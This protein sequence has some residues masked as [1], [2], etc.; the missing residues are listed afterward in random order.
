MQR[1]SGI[2]DMEAG[3]KKIL[4]F[5][6]A[7]IILLCSAVSANAAGYTCPTY[8]KYI[9]CSA[10][11]YLSNCG[12]ESNWTGQTIA[13]SALSVGNS[14]IK[15][16][17]AAYSYAGGRV[18]PKMDKV[19]CSAGQ[20]LPKNSSAC[21]T[22]K[23]GNYCEG[24]S[25][26]V[27]Y[28]SDQGLT[29][30][31]AGTANASTG[32][33]TVSACAACANG[34]Y[35]DATGQTSC[36]SCP[37]ADSTTQRTT[38]PDEYYPYVPGTSSYDKTTALSVL[39][40]ASQSWSNGG[41]SIAACK[42]IYGIE[43]A[44]G[45]FTVS[46][47]GYNATTKKYDVGGS[48]YYHYVKPGYYLDTKYLDTYC[49]TAT[50]YMFYRKAIAC[51][52]GAYC[53][54]GSTPQCNT[55]TYA[56]T[57]GKSTCPTN[58][59]SAA[60][61]TAQAECY[62]MITLDKNK[63]SG[64][65]LDTVSTTPASQKCFYGVA[66]EFPSSAVLSYTGDSMIP[67]K[68]AFNGW[69]TAN[70]CTS[71]T[72][73]FT[74]TSTAA[75]VTYYACR[76]Q[77]TDITFNLNGG[78]G[79]KP[80]D[81]VADKDKAMP[82]LG[83]SSNPTRTG[84]DFQGWYDNADYTKGT[85]YYTAV[86]AS[87][88]TWNKTAATATLYAGWKAQ[89]YTCAAGYYLNVTACA[90]CSAGY[91]CPAESQTYTYNG[92]IQ[93]RTACPTAAS[94]VGDIGT[95][96]VTAAHP[97][98]ASSGATSVAHCLALSVPYTNVSNGS[99]LRRCFYTSGAS[100]SAVYSTDCQ[101][102]RPTSCNAGAQPM[103]D[104]AYT[105]ASD[106][107]GVVCTLCPAGTYKSSAGMAAC[108]SCPTNW[109][110]A[111]GANA[112]GQCYRMITLDKNGG[113]G[114]IA[115]TTATGA[116]SNVTGT[117]S[118][119]HRCYYNTSCNLPSV[120]GLT[121]A[122]Y[123]YIGWGTSATCLDESTTARITSTAATVKYYACKD[124]N[125]YAITLDAN[126][127]SGGDG[128]VYQKYGHGWSL[129]NFGS[130]IP[131]L[132]SLPTKSNSL[133]NGYY[134]A[135]TNG[136]QR[137]PADGVLPAY[138]TFTA[139]TTIYAQYSACAACTKGT[140]VAS[141]G[142]SVKN[143]ACTY[144]ATCS[145]GYKTPTCTSAGACSCTPNTYNIAF[146]LNGAS[147][148]KPATITCTYGT[149][150]T[151]PM[152][153]GITSEDMV[154]DG[155]S[156]SDNSTQGTTYEAG[157]S[158]SDL[159]TTDNATVTLYARLLR[160]A[161]CDLFGGVG[162]KCSVSVINNQCVYATSCKVNYYNL[163]GG[164]THHPSCTKCPDNSTTPDGNS[165]TSCACNTGYSVDGTS[166]GSTSTTGNACTAITY[167]ISYTLNG[168]TQATSGV[169]TSYTYG[170]A[171]TINGI[172]TRSGYVFAGWCTN[173]GLTSCAMSQ[174]VA[175]D[176]TGD[177]TFYAKWTA[178]TCAATHGS[179][180][181][182][183]ITGNAPVCAITCATGYS[184]NGGADSTGTFNVTG[185]AGNASASGTCNAR[186]FTVTYACGTGTTGTAPSN[187]TA[188]YDANFTPAANSSCA[189]VG[190]TFAGW[191]DGTTDRAAGTAFKW[192]YSENKTF[193]AKWTPITF[194]VAYAAG[195]GSGSAPSAP[196]TC[197]YNGTCN[198]PANT[199]SRS[200]YTFK[201][202]KCTSSSGNC[203]AATYNAGAGISTATTV[204]GAT[205]TLTA[206]WNLVTYTITY[207]LN[208]GTN[209]A[210]NPANYNVTTNTITLQNPTREN[211]TFGGWFTSSALTGTAVTQIANGS[212][213]NKTF[214]AKWSCNTGYTASADGN[215][216]VAR[217]DL[218]CAAGQYLDG[219]T[220]R[221]CTSGYHC[222]ATKQTYTYNGGIQGRSGC[223]TA[224]SASDAKATSINSCYLTTTATKYVA[225]AGAGLVT[226]A[227]GG[228][229]AGGIK[230]YYNGTGGR[231]PCTS[232]NY[233]AAGASV[234]S[235]CSDL[236]GISISGTYTSVSPF[237]AKTTCR[238]TADSKTITGCSNVTSNTVA[239]AGT[240]W[241]TPTY[242]VTASGGYIIEN[243]DT[244]N[245]TCSACGDGTYST[246][247]SATSCS[248]C[249]AL[250]PAVA[251]T[252]GNYTSVSPRNANSTCRYKAPTP[253]KPEHCATMV[254]NTISYSGTAWGTNIYT[255]TANAGAIIS[256]NNSAAATC[257]QCAAGGYSAGGTATSCT[258][259]AAPYS[260]SAA[261]ST[262]RNDCYLTTD[263]GNYVKVA[264]GGQVTCEKGNYCTGGSVVYYGGTVA[265]RNTTGGMTAC[266]A[267]KYNA[268]T[269]SSAASA[270]V[271][272]AT[273]SYASGTGNTS[274]TACQSGKTT[275]G[276]GQTSCNANCGNAANVGA[277]KSA[278]WAANTV[279][280]LCAI[281]AAAANACAPAV[282][283]TGAASASYTVTG[284][285][286]VY[287]G[288]CQAKFYNPTASG[289]TVSCSGCPAAYPNS[290]AGN[291][292]DS[293]AYCYVTLKAG[294]QVASAGA[295]VTDCAKGHYCTSAGNIFKGTAG[296][297]AQYTGTACQN[298]S[299]QDETG[300]TV[301]KAC[302][303]GKTNSGT[304]NVA[305]CTT[306]CTAISGLSAWETTGWDAG[307]VS[308]L[309]TVKTCAAD[310][311]KNG[312]ACPTCS[313]G[314]GGK[315]PK[316]VAG[317][318]S[319]N[320]C[321]LITDAGKYVAT[322]KAGQ[323]ECLADNYCVGNM[324]VY[325]GTGTQTG[326]SATCG[327]G[328]NNK[329]TK[330][331]AG[332][333]DVAECYLTLTAGH[334]VASAGAGVTDCGAGKYCSSTANIYYSADGGTAT[335][336]G[337]NCPAGTY[338]T[339]G[340][341]NS[342]CTAALAGYTAAVCGDNKYSNAGA[343][344]CSNC[345]TD[346]KY[347][348]SG[349]TAAAH[350]GVASCKASC[351]GSEYVSAAGAGCV[352]VGDGY[353]G[354]SAA[355]TAVAQNATLARTQCPVGYRDGAA[356]T[357]EANCAMNVD[358][359]K[360]VKV[361]NESAASGVCAA[362]TAKAAHVVTYG[363]TSACDTCAA[364]SYTSTTGKSSCDACPAGN[365]CTGGTNVTEC[366]AGT[367]RSATGGTTQSSCSNCPTL[368]NGYSYAST[369]GLT[370]V[371]SCTETKAYGDVSN[372]CHGGLLTK[373][374]T[375]ATT[376]KTATST[377]TAKAGAHLSGSGDNT[378][379]LQCTG[380]TYQTTNGAVVTACS[381]CPAAESDWSQG[382]GTGWT[383]ATSC[384][385]TKSVGGNCSAGQLKKNATSAPAWPT[386]ATISIALQANPGSYVDGQTC[387]QC[388]GAVWSAGGAVTSCSQCPGQTDKWTRNSGT[389]WTAVT[390]CNQ[391]R[392][393]DNCAGGLIRQNA[394]STTAWG[395]SVVD[396]ALS[397]NA[398]YYVS[399]VACPSCANIANTNGFYPNSAN[400][401][402]GGASACYTNSITG[403]YVA[404]NAS[405]STPCAVGSYKGAHTVKYGSSSVCADCTNKPEN[406][407][408]TGNATTNA[409]PWECDDGYNQTTANICAQLCTAGITELKMA[410][411]VVIPLYT[412]KQ[413][414]RAIAIGYNGSVCY[415]SLASGQGTGALNVS[416]DGVTYH[417][418]K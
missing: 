418:I 228:A 361:K 241:N 190:H 292:Y 273:G 2:F 246:G 376:W 131:A 115:V 20:Y 30:C 330:S 386:T 188:T 110:S 213:G 173:S 345:N 101:M 339:G 321:Y 239:Y 269:G 411:G 108:T 64:R 5:V 27:N 398:G 326:G 120:A 46:S 373:V 109:T 96:A 340:A 343:S 207:N 309:C 315:Y 267:G 121:Y 162:A 40:I 39:S 210:D 23:A 185:T 346:N 382:T 11:Y 219:V 312:N 263:A 316:S 75:S 84:Y 251:V 248:L 21:V 201:N 80:T 24:G 338:S 89:T 9:S 313:S 169:P 360:Y 18:C 412:S 42:A 366:S 255:V 335:Y 364:G 214:Y 33:K 145:A 184:K 72:N 333:S 233:A 331:A 45:R 231:T 209:A 394:T 354:R 385:E 415:G 171:A 137:I 125:V 310:Y 281:D 344:V 117:T 74:I 203:A 288:T 278:S 368:T 258:T 174:T 271:A 26:T 57:W 268:S 77:Q 130:V 191:N 358:G 85:Q 336:T 243:N 32:G 198:A 113:S 4:N 181:L 65:L 302:A 393:P 254:S 215:S 249:S 218:E 204:A 362:G 341:T 105:D 19:T 175:A 90:E 402:T 29:A 196:V 279:T 183:G 34:M 299:Y 314:T 280:N 206:D 152:Q 284:N 308:N 294:Q 133:F 128:V 91:Y 142:I 324:N 104:G 160:C 417:T 379:C 286:C 47:V 62:R 73:S 392:K 172:P 350:A 82:A 367:Y 78:S 28:A 305:A 43:N 252:G 349:T 107:D 150:C 193:T 260:S 325:Y 229:C 300:K 95:W 103:K 100:G 139:D 240:A 102:M 148:V 170:T 7:C 211:S 298:G 275:N 265:G 3:V 216:C 140:G 165:A 93:G 177:K 256:G 63:G 16:T 225:T 384:F 389:G 327:S 8:K 157:A 297:T 52:V 320:S 295:G 200:G 159:T 61:A 144:T 6:F 244:A 192:A 22:C 353:Y 242:S 334:Q 380:A 167:N 194:N 283:G 224:Y 217:S 322:A 245:A 146:D 352:T 409:C 301:C 372:Y 168:G 212:T 250:T 259:C 237:N 163:T 272:C 261:G 287:S 37:T 374:A 403:A 53:P 136:T 31:P 304:G 347:Y 291:A 50:N 147:G 14:C 342:G 390:Q 238:F 66:C 49:D 98:G 247:G 132:S 348:N 223:P 155:W 377:L 10:G 303:A 396:S 122:N 234:C 60:N 395:A 381:P 363:N 187:G 79:T 92:E 408:Y 166:A 413:T 407:A 143:N 208:G 87:A 114:T 276:T 266:A 106:T 355:A 369:T 123:T 356:T 410:G 317:T 253:T 401:N 25:F 69:G 71:G 318:T 397:A 180:T 285:A 221:D 182:S 41:S 230:V 289:V 337:S 264:S 129:T 370:A 359:G 388:D 135:K 357:A 404:K 36:K 55:G 307:V 154:V 220:C 70:S 164:G 199:Y 156:T 158:V 371:T 12:A 270:C 134:T 68:W 58:W 116:T 416:S 296:G 383:A 406:S 365:Y 227:A 178:A 399:G 94:D 67:E 88:R 38:F 179:A 405:A 282:N 235:A 262:T 189:K 51:P 112:Q 351:S 332:A 1:K 293:D 149:P 59:T 329:Y 236:S 86:R 76:Q 205:I 311:Y 274:C 375:N 119:S 391:T 138:D 153:D 306:A 197:T 400:A 226:C 387:T 118:G 124:A 81:K 176:A 35:Q 328:T 186:T 97:N 161:P 319:V 83:V 15:G 290:V 54:G 111:T 44:A 277:W 99:G 56:D 414:D 323:V 141:C 13:E 195:G 222:P 202:W 257:S 127:G 126:G 48:M 232:P 17:N 151:L 378:T